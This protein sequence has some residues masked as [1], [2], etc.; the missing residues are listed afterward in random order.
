MTACDNADQA[1]PM[2]P[3][4]MNRYHW[5]FDDPAHAA[6]QRGRTNGVFRLVH[7]EIARVFRAYAAGV[8]RKSH[9]PP[10][11]AEITRLRNGG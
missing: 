5:G 4:Q 8:M 7:D 6:G 11:T 2:F 1:C 10:Q 3:G 9:A